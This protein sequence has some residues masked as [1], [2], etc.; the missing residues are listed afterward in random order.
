MGVKVGPQVF[1]I[2][3]SDCLKSLQRHTQIYIN[4]LLTG[5]HPKLCGKNKILDS[6][7]Y[8]AEH[9]QNVVKFFDKLEE[10]HLKVH[11]EK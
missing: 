2:M 8:L 3:V 6:K 11:F 7:A 10:C 5:I 1:Q 9:S 4:D